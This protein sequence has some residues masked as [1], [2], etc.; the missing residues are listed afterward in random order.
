[1]TKQKSALI[2]ISRVVGGSV[3]RRVGGSDVIHVRAPETD[4]SQ[5]AAGGGGAS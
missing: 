2:E 3:E 4:A 5:G 1:M